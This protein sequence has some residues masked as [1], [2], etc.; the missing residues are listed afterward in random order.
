M[1]PPVEVGVPYRGTR[2]FAFASTEIWNLFHGAGK[3]E[4]PTALFLETVKRRAFCS[5]IDTRRTITVFV[6]NLDATRCVM[7]RGWHDFPLRELIAPVDF[8]FLFTDWNNHAY[9]SRSSWGL[10]A[11]AAA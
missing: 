2:F 10:A 1:L 8:E 7:H 9:L 6:G 11:T 4:F 3:R 5:A